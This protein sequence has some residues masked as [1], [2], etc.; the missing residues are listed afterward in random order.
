MNPTSEKSPSSPGT[1]LTGGRR[2]KP[3][4][5]T[6]YWKCNRTPLDLVA[7]EI[8][9]GSQ[10]ATGISMR[11]DEWTVDLRSVTMCRIGLNGQM[12]LHY[13]NFEQPITDQNKVKVCNYY[14]CYNYQQNACT[15][16]GLYNP[17]TAYCLQRFYHHSINNCHSINHC[18]FIAY[19][20]VIKYKKLKR[21]C[22]G[23]GVLHRSLRDNWPSNN[24][25]LQTPYYTCTV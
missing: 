19:V 25:G 4:I 24:H 7:N 12:N 14:M 5:F 2:G 11:S 23:F 8:Q 21:L 15:T 18:H 20:W 17:S 9:R 16:P 3:S 10:K 22:K 1:W 6:P 13:L